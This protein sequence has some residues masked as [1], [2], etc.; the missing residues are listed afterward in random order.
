MRRNAPPDSA[1]S[2][3]E[4]RKAV[5]TA[6]RRSGLSPEGWLARVEAETRR[7]KSSEGSPRAAREL[8]AV[9]D[10]IV[11]SVE[12]PAAAGPS[13]GSA[14]PAHWRD[15]ARTAMALDSLADWIEQN[16]DR[17]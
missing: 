11:Q 8:D 16:Q 5:E 10:G 7:L 13:P 1:S 14:D 15:P 12:P 2:E 9:I 6:A 4:I 3:I 17:L